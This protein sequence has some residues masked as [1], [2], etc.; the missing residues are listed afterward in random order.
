[1]IKIHLS[2]SSMYLLS[3]L[4]LFFCSTLSAQKDMLQNIEEK[5]DQDYKYLFDLYK[6][7]HQHPELS[8]KEENTS[9]RMAEEL[10]KIGYEVS[11][12]F[13]GYGVVGVLKNGEGPTVMVR[14]DMDALPL[15]E[16]TNKPYASAVTTKDDSGAEVGVMHACGHDIHMTV[17]TGTAR[18]LVELKDQWKG[19]LV[20]IG[21]PAE[22]RGGGAKAM[23]ADGLYEKF[24]RPD[25]A[26]A[27]HVNA[28]LEAG[29][30]A[31]CPKY[32]MANVDMVDISIFGEGGH[33]AYPHTTKDPIVLAARLIMDLQTIVSREISPLEPAVL[34]V[35]SIHGGSKHN[36]IP[37]EVKLELTLRSYS[38][39]VRNALIE[40]IKRTCEGV[41]KSA[42][43]PDDKLPTVFVREEYCP[44]LYNDPVLVERMKKTFE[45]A[46]GQ[47]NVVPASPV[48]GGE[49]FSRYG[50]EEPKVPIML[51]W[52]GAVEP[53]K[54]ATYRKGGAP[55]P[56]LHSSKFAPLPEPTIKTG[57]ITMTAA[58]LDLLK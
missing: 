15:K 13:G 20:F 54:V 27:L 57:V 23:L 4:L 39:E 1:M 52:L 49:D 47:Q 34:T 26:L 10:Q 40:K 8:F 44:A 6:H 12:N 32:S 31:Y 46:I 30:V 55:L 41:A 7:Y 53:E 24:P 37:D 14:A 21:Q 58:V 56:S 9:K 33:G 29:K 38:D 17:W 42:G 3:F 51:Y 28:S 16:E 43:I 48:M 19:T 5:V 35:G 2:N 50:R 11:T 22:E 45:A 18:R 25:Y 36:I